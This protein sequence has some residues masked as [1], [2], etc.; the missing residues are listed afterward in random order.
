MTKKKFLFVGVA[1]LVLNTASALAQARPNL[2]LQRVIYNTMKTMAKPQGELKDKLDAVDKEMAEAARAGRTGEVRHLLAKGTTFLSGKEW[3]D[4]LEFSNSLVMRAEEVCLD[5]SLPYTIRLE[6]IYAPRVQLSGPLTV[7]LT[8]HKLGRSQWGVQAGEKVKDLGQQD[9]VGRDLQ[10]DPCRIELD[11]SGNEDGTF[12]LQAEILEKERSLGTTSLLIGLWKGLSER[13]RLIEAELKKIETFDSFRADVLYP[14]DHI[15]NLNRGRFEMGTFQVSAELKAAEDVLT[16]IKN[17]QDPFA[18]RTGDME[19]HYLLEG[20]N[21]IMPYRV[22]VPKAYSGKNVYPLII[23]LHGLGATEDSFFDSYDKQIPKLAEEH[24][25]IVAA[26]F[27]YRVDGFYGMSLFGNPQDESVKRRA[28]Y[29]ERDVMNVLALMRKN[30][31]IDESR[32]YLM[33]HSMGAIGTWHLGAKYS[34]VWAAL[35]PFAGFGDPT[36]VAKMKHIPEIV[37]HGDADPTVPVSGSR[38]M[39]A[40]MKK[41]GV[42]VQYIEVPKGNHIDI[43]VPNLGAV[44]NFFDKHRKAASKISGK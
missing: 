43:V 44:F 14:L 17:G 1:L 40:E 23:A 32:I 15:R 10:D 21:E 38:A 34:E 2:A 41:Q 3:T 6:Q 30:Y 27:G 28:E 29:S 20:A 4:V 12:L 35:A 25:Y 18:G 13:L 5:S 11:L 31:R 9:G 36:T 24:G 42:Q 16:S 33:G 22:Y 26:P 8:L 37:V 19:R 7:R 39:V